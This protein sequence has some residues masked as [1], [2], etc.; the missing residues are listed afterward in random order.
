MPLFSFSKDERLSSKKSIEKLF[1]EGSS[2]FIYP[3]KVYWLLS[4]KDTEYPAQV[5]ISV[6]KR[7]FKRAVDRNKTKRRIRELYRQNKISL[8]EHLEPGDRRCL[9]AII[10]TSGAHLEYPELERKIKLVFRRLLQELSS[11]TEQ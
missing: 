2:F 10:Y 1:R 5:M 11:V 6:G 7:A 9:L 4:P 3:F 8:Y